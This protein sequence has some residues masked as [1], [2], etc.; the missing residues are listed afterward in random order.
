[1]SKELSFGQQYRKLLALQA[2]NQANALTDNLDEDRNK[3]SLKIALSN[4]DESA[5]AHIDSGY[6]F[7]ELRASVKSPNAGDMMTAASTKT[8]FG[9]HALKTFIK[10]T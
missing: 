4:A 6:K 10:G 5:K 1:M 8:R 2:R 7:C 3:A 9:I